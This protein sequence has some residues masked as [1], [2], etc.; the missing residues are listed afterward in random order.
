MLTMLPVA[1]Q[2]PK[3]STAVT[4]ITC[5]FG[6]H[7]TTEKKKLSYRRHSTH[8]TSLYHMVWWTIYE[9]ITSTTDRQMDEQ[10][11]GQRLKPQPIVL[12]SL[13][14]SNWERS[15]VHIDYAISI[16]DSSTLWHRIAQRSYGIVHQCMSQHARCSPAQT[17]HT[18]N[19]DRR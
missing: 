2:Q 17:E 4:P 19:A 16:T 12:I 8:L 14:Q 3:Q 6:E 10:T 5:T 11:G 18:N 9:W 15:R 1:S 7:V 13:F